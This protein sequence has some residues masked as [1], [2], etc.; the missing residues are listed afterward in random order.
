MNLWIYGIFWIL[1]WFCRNIL[2][3]FSLKNHEKGGFHALDPA[4]ADVAQL[5][6]VAAPQVSIGTVP[7]WA[8]WAPMW[9]VDLIS[10]VGP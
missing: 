8:M 7:P 5:Y 10:H 6:H 3:L 1:F 2:D 9:R 4:R